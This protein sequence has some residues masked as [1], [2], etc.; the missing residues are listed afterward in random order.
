M[1]PV[2]IGT[3]MPLLSKHHD[4]SNGG[5]CCPLVD[6][7]V[8]GQHSLEPDCIFIPLAEAYGKERQVTTQSG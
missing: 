1:V 7:Y 4:K 5:E 6:L 8:G 3:H 2:S